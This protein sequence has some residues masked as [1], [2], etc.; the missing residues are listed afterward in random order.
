M[1]DL[2]LGLNQKVNFK[3]KLVRNKEHYRTDF[4]IRTLLSSINKCDGKHLRTIASSIAYLE[5]V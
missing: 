4:E 2:K 1:K 3:K 5:L